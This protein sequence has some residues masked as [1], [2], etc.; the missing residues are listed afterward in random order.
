MMQLQP[1][2]ESMKYHYDI[3]GSDGA[4]VVVS[5]YFTI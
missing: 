5:S 4:P 1:K 3:I 2:E